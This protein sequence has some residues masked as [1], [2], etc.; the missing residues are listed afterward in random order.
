MKRMNHHGAGIRSARRFA[1]AGC[2]AAIGLALSTAWSQQPGTMGPVINKEKEM[3]LTGHKGLVRSVSFS[4]DSKL[5]AS[6]SN[7]H[8]VRLWD[9]TSGKEIHSITNPYEE[10]SAVVFSPDGKML[11]IVGR[12]GITFVRV[13]AWAARKNVIV[14]YHSGRVALF[15]PR[16]QDPRQ[17]RPR[18]ERF[19]SGM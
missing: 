1:L 8:T 12:L 18:Q 16:Q 10:Y 17:R 4:P 7:D 13:E 2:I 11:A 5:L 9:L 19:F 3:T 15:Q 14:Q 6:S